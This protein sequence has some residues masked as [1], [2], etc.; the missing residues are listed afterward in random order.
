M[1]EE[2]LTT[3]AYEPG[4]DGTWGG[5]FYIDANGCM[6]HDPE[7]AVAQTD[8]EC[9]MGY[10]WC[11]TTEQW[12]D[13]LRRHGSGYE[14]ETQYI[15]GAETKRNYTPD[16][17]EYSVLLEQYRAHRSGD[18]YIS[19]L[20][21]KDGKLT[22]YIP[23]DGANRDA[24]MA[25][26]GAQARNWGSVFAISIHPNGDQS[27]KLYD[28]DVGN[29]D[30]P[31]LPA[32]AAIGQSKNGNSLYGVA[33]TW[34]NGEEMPE[35]E[36]YFSAPSASVAGWAAPRGLILPEADVDYWGAVFNRQGIVTHLKALKWVAKEVGEVER[37]WVNGINVR[38]GFCGCDESQAILSRV[39]KS[40]LAGHI[41]NVGA[42]EYD[43]GEY[44]RHEII[45]T[46]F[47]GEVSQ[48][49]RDLFGVPEHIISA[50]WYGLKY[51]PHYDCEWLK[52]ADMD[53]SRYTLPDIPEN[54]HRAFGV[55]TVYAKTQDQPPVHNASGD[56]WRDCSFITRDHAAVRAWCLANGL[57]DPA[58]HLPDTLILL[59]VYSITHHAETG[60]IKR[61]KFYDY[62]TQQR[63]E[64]ELYLSAMLAGRGAGKSFDEPLYTEAVIRDAR[65]RVAIFNS[66]EN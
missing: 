20:S 33:C 55:A 31:A 58:P 5:P 53:Y 13:P 41:M 50:P 52:L 44:G 64:M 14:Y 51:C 42:N 49:H 21:K 57:D 3:Q 4:P 43:L 47:K 63:F 26:F 45:S 18:G 46:Y 39:P 40:Y 1:T 25:E 8:T 15:D 17:P 65:D 38:S 32:V 61:V 66:M 36:V 16:A 7:Q 59:G 19:V 23:D 62:H 6:T 9:P 22:A 11:F 35:R 48:Y 27:I 12:V 56:G 29:Y 28:E 54:A 24:A 60:E 37:C 2:F 34:M 10:I 30:L